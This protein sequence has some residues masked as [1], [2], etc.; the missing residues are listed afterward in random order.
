MK[1]GRDKPEQEPRHEQSRKQ[2][3]KQRTAPPLAG[4]GRGEGAATTSLL[5]HACSMRRDPTPAERLLWQNLRNRRIGNF[6]FRRQVPLRP[7]IADF[8]C[9]AAQLVVEVDG[10]S[11]IEP[12]A[13]AE[14]DSW[15]ARHGIR[16]LRFA[17]R[18]VFSNVEGV[19]IEI[20]LVAAAFPSPNPLPQGEGGSEG[21]SPSVSPPNV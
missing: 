2:K 1:P 18:D 14:R 12:S 20:G 15:M 19:L 21:F 8:Y 9:S 11:H 16:V 10:I 4:G 13:D 3:Q 6:K 7:Y 17:N 5:A